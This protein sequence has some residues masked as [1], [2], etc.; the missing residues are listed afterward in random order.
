M[1]SPNSWTAAIF[2]AFAS[3]TYHDAD[4]QEDD[5]EQDDGEWAEMSVETVECLVPISVYAGNTAFRAM[6][7]TFD[8]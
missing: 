4:E 8:V 1:K 3:A 6:E 5:D 7:V 2:N